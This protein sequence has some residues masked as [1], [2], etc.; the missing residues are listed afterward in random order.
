MLSSEWGTLTFTISEVHQSLP[1]LMHMAAGNN[2]ET[3]SKQS[4]VKELWPGSSGA[5]PQ[6]TI[7]LGS[8]VGFEWKQF[9]EGWQDS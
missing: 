6:L 2:T 7:L 8:L 1:Q 3:K 4:C 5:S 9:L